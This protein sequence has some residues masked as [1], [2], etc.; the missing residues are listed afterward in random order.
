M[1]EVENESLPW[2]EEFKYLGVQN[3]Q[4]PRIPKLGHDWRICSAADEIPAPLESS[5]E[6]KV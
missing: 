6:K 4:N 3:K 1:M 2:L 5:L